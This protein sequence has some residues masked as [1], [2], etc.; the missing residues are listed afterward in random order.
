MKVSVFGLG[1]VGCVSIACL[2]QMRHRVIGVDIIES[3]VNAIDNGIP[4]VIEPEV[5]ELIETG[6][7]EGR[8]SATLD[9]KQATLSTDV[10]L[11]CVGTPADKSGEHVLTAVEATADAI[12]AALLE[13]EDGHL[14]VIRSTMTPGVVLNNLLPRIR[15]ADNP[16]SHKVSVVLI[17]EFLRE[18]TAV[19]D[20]YNP[21]L[22]VVGT[23]DGEPD[24]HQALIAEMLCVDPEAIQWVGY[25]IAVMMK[26]LCNVFHA[27][28]VTFAN[29]VGS[30]CAELGIDGRSVMH[31]L[32]QDT[33]LN[34][35][36]AYLR[37]GMPYGGSCL[38]KDLSATVALAKKNHV[39]TPLLK[40][41]GESNEAHKERA[42]AAAL[43][44][45]G[46]RAIG[47]DGLSFKSGTDDL[48]ESPMVQLAEHLIGKG[49]DLRILDPDVRT[50]AL[51]GANREYIETRIPHL[52]E[53][54]VADAAELLDHAEVIILTRDNDDL[55]ALA[56]LKTPAPQ[57]IDLTGAGRQL[58]PEESPQTTER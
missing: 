39:D 44:A 9:S 42:I 28:K 54:L 22:V 53:R 7:R 1:Y 10:S 45:A 18:A 33:K 4:T 37:P 2:S 5:T 51:T 3:K 40:A 41:I 32:T 48:R 21:P 38:P 15:R 24:F 14:V 34:I 25:G 26:T 16:N 52:A 58:K 6:H 36:P 23:I 57:V 55:L 8:I 50:S 20:Y 47:L 29:E 17:P 43:Q 11:V 27:M 13:K 35:S 46:S 12:G 19:Q 49:F 56:R 30:L 31:L